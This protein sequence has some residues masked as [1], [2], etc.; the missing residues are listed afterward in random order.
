[1]FQYAI[2][3]NILPK[4]SIRASES[5]SAPFVSIL[6]LT[7]PVDDDNKSLVEPFTQH[8]QAN[9]NVFPVPAE[10]GKLTFVLDPKARQWHTSPTA[11]IE[12]FAKH[13]AAYYDVPIDTIFKCCS[14]DLQQHT[15]NQKD[16]K[17]Q[18]LLGNIKIIDSPDTTHIQVQMKPCGIQEE[19]CRWLSDFYTV[20]RKEE[21]G[22][23]ILDLNDLKG[24]RGGLTKGSQLIQLARAI[25]NAW[26]LTYS[27]II[28]NIQPD[29]ARHYSETM[30]QLQVPHTH[31][32]DSAVGPDYCKDIVIVGGGFSG[33]STTVQ[34]LRQLLASPPAKPIRIQ[35]LER[36]PNYFGAGL[37]YGA[38]GPEHHVNVEAR[39]LSLDPDNPNDFVDWLKTAHHTHHLG[40]ASM[41]DIP[42]DLSI[43]SKNP[44][45]A[46]VQRRLYHYYLMDR[47]SETVAEARADGVADFDIRFHEAIN[48][49]ITSEQVRIT[50][51]NGEVMQGTD[52]VLA[53]GHGPAALLPF[54]VPIQGHE[55]VVISEWN[56]HDRIETIFKDPTVKD[57]TILGTGL[58]AMDYL[59]TA[60]QLGWLAD[61]EH[62]IHLMSRGGHTH[63][64]LKT[65]SEYQEP[66]I[67][68]NNYR[69]KIPTSVE[70]VPDFA[71]ETFKTL[72][73]SGHQIIGREY[74]K[75]EVFNAMTHHIPEFL[76][77]S[78]LNVHELGGLLK[79]YSSL[80]NT[81]GVSMA[82]PIGHVF[83][84][85]THDGQAII[86][87]A[88]P[89]TIVAD[90]KTLIIN[91]LENGAP[92]VIR[93]RTHCFRLYRHKAMPK[94]L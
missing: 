76:R 40:D 51:D 74:T 1:M 16:Q 19:F 90:G 24:T 22:C 44:A 42:N 49:D 75:E 80:L 17:R 7:M 13:L 89:Q 81:T 43:P 6:E 55:R 36:N 62:K 87:S 48:A 67:D 84:H 45:I 46:A 88:E 78:G 93:R 72:Q 58:S 39:Y 77:V 4:L 25:E 60:K 47:L 2:A 15:A 52:L 20:E 31:P 41:L 34:T 38:A 70:Q 56:Q 32:N 30:A 3:Q 35:M 66:I 69:D 79:K 28:Q 9:Y 21:N 83:N 18:E 14:Q 23:V 86:V 61:P 65:G 63:D 33:V 91:A 26:G 68:I 8:L 59:V 73:T 5:T 12:S 64:V 10:E 53:N 71:A 82:G 29:A 92:Q 57:V 54:L 27:E 37:A 85:Y 50:L 94:S 11:N